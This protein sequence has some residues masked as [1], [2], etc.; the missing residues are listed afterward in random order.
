[1]G[2]YSGVPHALEVA[3]RGR[4]C[5]SR[6]ASSPGIPLR[7][8]RASSFIS[9]LLELVRTDTHGNLCTRCV[10]SSYSSGNVEADQVM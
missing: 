9:P 1:M 8:H 4:F 10:R 7:L 3:V 2:K 6:S 5:T